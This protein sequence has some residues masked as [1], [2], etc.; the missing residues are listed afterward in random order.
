ML[1]LLCFILMPF[2]KKK[3]ATG[4]EIDFD[5]VYEWSEGNTCYHINPRRRSYAK[6]EH[7][8]KSPLGL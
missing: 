3:D 7:L 2:G 8:H 5:T 4:R 6:T 1:T